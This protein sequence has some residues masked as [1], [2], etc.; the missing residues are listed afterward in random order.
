M[1]EAQRKNEVIERAM[2][3]LNDAGY[4]SAALIQTSMV[5]LFVDEKKMQI[6]FLARGA[7]AIGIPVSFGLI[8]KRAVVITIADKQPVF[9]KIA[10]KNLG[11]N[12]RVRERL[13]NEL[14]QSI[15]KGEGQEKVIQRIKNVVGEA[16]YNAKRTAQTECTRVRAQARQEAAEEA[17]EQGL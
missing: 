3:H 5:D 4:K 2:K 9:A 17:E 16:D 7:K 13:Q 14:A 15:I 1:R 8:D 10:Y 6:E 11:Q 12:I